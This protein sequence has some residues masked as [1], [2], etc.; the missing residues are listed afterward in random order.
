MKPQSPPLPLSWR[1]RTSPSTPSPKPSREKKP[2][3]SAT[4]PPRVRHLMR[5]MRGESWHLP[6]DLH[7]GKNTQFR[8]CHPH[9]GRLKAPSPSPFRGRGRGRGLASERTGCRKLHPSP[10]RRM[11]QPQPFRMQHQP[12]IVPRR[13][14]PHRSDHPESDAQATAYAPATDGSA[15]SADTSA[16]ASR[17]RPARSPPSRSPQAARAHDPPSGAADSP[18]RHKAAGPP[19]PDPASITPGHPRDIG[20]FR[21]RRFSNSCP[22]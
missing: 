16:P 5:S 12:G 15:R 22:R 6:C 20:L 3:A 17:R 21:A 13:T 19:G 18:N 9:P 4:A 11:V 2:T 14:R 10:A 7:L 1:P 8:P